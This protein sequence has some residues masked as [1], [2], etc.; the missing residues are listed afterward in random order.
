MSKAYL[1]AIFLIVAS[2]TGCIEDDDDDNSP[3][4][5][6]SVNSFINS[7]D[8]QKWST[9]CSYHLDYEATFMNFTERK[10]CIDEWESNYDEAEEYGLVKLKTTTDN[11]SAEKLDYKASKTSGYVYSVSMSVTQCFTYSEEEEE[12]CSDFYEDDMLWVK[13]GGKWGYGEDGFEGYYPTG[14]SAP[15]ATFTVE[16]SSSGEYYV[17]VIKVSK[18]ED[19]AG[20]KYYLKDETGSTYVGGNGFGEIALQVIAGEEHG[21]ENTYDGDDEVLE[22]RASNVSADDGSEYPVHFND[23]DRD[24]KL[25]AGDQFTVFGT[26]NSA[27]G[28]AKSGWKL[29]IQFDATGDIVGWGEIN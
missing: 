9:F 3:S 26:G 1:F 18:Q 5:R 20:F 13:V 15:I 6:E 14:E 25:S 12:D 17:K 4:L 19:L 8:A 2:F 29:D 22:R 24:G 7:L 23:N 27:N 16:T 11:Y 21:I 10:E 28:P